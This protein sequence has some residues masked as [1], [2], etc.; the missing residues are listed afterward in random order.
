MDSQDKNQAIFLAIT[1]LITTRDF[2]DSQT[3]FIQQNYHH[4]DDDEENKHIYKTVY[5][6][7]LEIMEKTIESKLMGDFKFGDEEINAFYTSFP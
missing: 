5:D 7:Y 4:F 2:L 1:E 3:A 6:N